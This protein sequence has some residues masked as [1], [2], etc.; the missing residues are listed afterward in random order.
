MLPDIVSAYP[1]LLLRNCWSAETSLPVE[2]EERVRERSTQLA[3]DTDKGRRRVAAKMRMERYIL[4]FASVGSV[5]V[6][7]CFGEFFARVA[8][9]FFGLLFIF[10]E[11]ALSLQ[12]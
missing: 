9:E 3:A 5:E 1:A 4:F 12:S 10:R 11:F 7:E 2:P 6:R 8:E